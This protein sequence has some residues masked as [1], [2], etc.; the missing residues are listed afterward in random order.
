MRTS[1]PREAQGPAGVGPLVRAT[2]SQAEVD[3]LPPYGDP[4]VSYVGE[5]ATYVALGASAALTYRVL[6][7]P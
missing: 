5:L 7:Q 6:R 3:L 4:E 1:H 2:R